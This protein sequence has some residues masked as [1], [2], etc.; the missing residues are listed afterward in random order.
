MCTGDDN[1]RME[2][3]A[4]TVE[5]GDRYRELDISGFTLLSNQRRVGAELPV[6]QLPGR[7]LLSETSGIEDARVV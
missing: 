5:H 3:H 7:E 1:S 2:R 6:G 4:V